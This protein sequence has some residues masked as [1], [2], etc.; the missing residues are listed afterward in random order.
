MIQKDLEIALYSAVREAKQRRHEYLTLE[1]LLY[2]LCFDETTRRTLRSCGANVDQLKRDLET[3]LDE[4]LDQL[5]AG[6]TAEPVQ[7]V[8][9]QRVMQRAIMHVRSS[10]QTE[11]DGGNVL[12]ALFSEPDSH[13][14]YFLESQGLTRL[15][16][17]SFIAHGVGKV[18]EDEEEED[19]FSDDEWEDNSL[20]LNEEEDEGE[21]LRN[22]LEA[23]CT[24]LVDRATRGHIDPLIG[25]DTE[26]ERTIQILCRRRKNNPVLVGEPGVGKTAV[27]EG[28]A[29][30]IAYGEVP[31][32]LKN[33]VIYSLDLGGLLAGT[34]FRGQFEQ[35]LKAVIK[36]LQK[37][38]GAILFIDEI[39]TIVGAG[40]TSGGTMDASNI[41]KPALATGAIRCIGSTTH[42]EF[43]K[44][45]ERDRALAR[46]FQ[47]V[48]IVEP[49]LEETH[50]ILQGLKK[51]YEDF[52]NVVYTEDALRL[53]AELADKHI[54]ERALPDKAIDVI[55]EA[56]SRHR[57]HRHLFK[58]NI[59]GVEQIEAVVAKIA[60]IPE[61]RVVGNERDRLQDLRQ[62][63]QRTVYGQDDAIDAVVTAV[64]MN[65]AGLT[66]ADKPVGSFIFAGP[67][68]VGKTEVA[69]QLA[70]ALNI[71]FIRFDMSEYMERHAV[72][73]LIGAPPGYVGYDQGGLLTERIRKSPHAVLL[74]DEIE[75]AHPDIYN[76]LLQV[77]DTARLTDNNGREAD[78]RNVILIM[79][80]NA[81]AQEMAQNVVGFNKG[82]DL[83]RSSKALEKAFS[84]E[85][86]NRLDGTI[87]FRPLPEG[88]MGRVV[89]K[90]I[91]E[92]DVQLGERNVHIQLTDAARHWLAVRGYDAKL[93]AR[94][95]GRVIQQHVKQPLAEEMLFGHLEHG[96]SVTID[97]DKKDELCFSFEARARTSE[98][99]ENS[100]SEQV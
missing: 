70:K 95:L 28:L 42:E 77:M 47:K 99:E 32:V 84:P 94:P 68:G 88:V 12:V 63:L 79:T 37:R 30:K 6:V 74:L 69:R 8:A 35:R 48:D 46:R 27:A 25:R 82:L 50:A 81:G 71:E 34:K 55:D 40:A 78:F 36:A 62:A 43:R 29:R 21:A 18:D 97:V 7:T 54:M 4:Q 20:N 66:Q 13:A 16:V 64:K 5:P 49:T 17:V 73:R 65:R 41:L 67:T 92:L 86:R 23:Y 56:G 11:V 93:G 51:H 44:S 61:I 80:S 45:F 15:D 60:R 57:V 22:P 26:I 91:A 2:V 3:F 59:V 9:F 83:T 1:H 87:I 85:F 10:G 52:H 19:G 98:D 38:K 31:D 100:V 14:V 89:D 53:A 76:V 75:K 39:H 90:F 24:N 33:A 72:S 96:G 58:D